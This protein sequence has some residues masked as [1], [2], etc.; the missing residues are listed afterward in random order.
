MFESK[1]YFCFHLSISLFLLTISE[2]PLLDARK[3]CVS[4]REIVMNL[5]DGVSLAALGVLPR[6]PRNGDSSIVLKNYLLEA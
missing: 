2:M 4:Y 3:S 6:A 5:L 1:G